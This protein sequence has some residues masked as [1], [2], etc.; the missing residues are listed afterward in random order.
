MDAKNIQ[1]F[2]MPGLYFEVYRDD[3]TRLVSLQPPEQ[4]QPWIKAG[5]KDKDIEQGLYLWAFKGRV[6][7]DQSSANPPLTTF[8]DT[9]GLGGLYGWRMINSLYPGK[10]AVVIAPGPPQQGSD[11][12]QAIEAA[13]QQHWDA[14]SN[15]VKRDRRG[16]L[17]YA[18]LVGHRARY[19]N[20]QGVLDPDVYQPGELTRTLCTPWTYDFRDCQCFYWASNKPDV[21]SSE[22]S[23]YPYLNFQRKNWQVEPQTEDIGNNYVGRRKRELD[24]SDLMVDWEQLRPVVNG[25]ECGQN[26]VPPPGPTEKGLFD[27]QQIID[28]LTYLASV[29]HALA[30]QY[31]YA[32]YSIE[33]PFEKPDTNDQRTLNIWAS[34]QVIFNIAVDEMRHFRWANQALKLLDAPITV[35]RATLL[36]RKLKVPFYLQSMTSE[37]LQWFIDVERPSRDTTA[38]LDGMYVGLLRSVKQLPDSEVDATTKQRL[39]EIIKLII[40][41]GE[42]HYQRFSSAEQNL[43]IYSIQTN[44]ARQDLPTWIRQ[45]DWRT[46]GTADPAIPI[47]TFYGIPKV[48]SS[49]KGKIL[50]LQSDAFYRGLLTTL[51][52]AFALQDN[53]HSGAALRQAITMMFAMNQINFELADEG[54]TPLFT[55]PDEFKAEPVE[56]S[57]ASAKKL[58]QQA[59]DQFADSGVDI[60]RSVGTGP[61]QGSVEKVLDYFDQACDGLADD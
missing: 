47:D 40:D 2:F 36:G 3:G 6:N 13:T 48:A 15:L 5:L 59:K 8:N 50:Q 38:G 60:S 20:E 31:L 22:D 4:A 37:Q 33:T 21:V 52:I 27:R 9:F 56:Q 7:A 41:E 53:S 11:K 35:D 42:D 58:L 18:I 43:S 28:E 32:F 55:L 45:G 16:K 23:K 26:Y 39:E 17:E 51:T 29:E 25:R 10:L 44:E 14:Q 61:H 34:A 57:T 24:Y 12:W 54:A 1:K 19:L 46:E 30:I 49:E